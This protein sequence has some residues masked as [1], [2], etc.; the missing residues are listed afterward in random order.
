MTN[1]FR[2]F[3]VMIAIMAAWNSAGAS[4]YMCETDSCARF[5]IASESRHDF[6]DIG[7]ADGPVSCDFIVNSIG[8]QPLIVSSTVTTCPCTQAAVDH[9][10]VQPNESLTVKV[11]YDP[12]LSPGPFE[13]VII[14]KT[15]AEPYNFIRLYV[16]GN[17]V[18][19]SLDVESKSKK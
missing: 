12:H 8:T 4:D 3:G 18:A 16:S 1:L 9:D 13:Q 6:G 10:I 5:A 19:A 2:Y 14:L 7:Q 15:N 11:T 17:I